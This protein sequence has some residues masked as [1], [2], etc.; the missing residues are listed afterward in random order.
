M[1]NK[2][3]RKVQVIENDYNPNNYNPFLEKDND[4]IISPFIGFKTV[5]ELM[6][7]STLLKDMIHALVD[8]IFWD[9]NSNNEDIL[10]GKSKNELITIIREWLKFGAGCFIL[11]ST[12]FEH[13]PISRCEIIKQNHD[14]FMRYD[15]GNSKVVFNIL[16]RTHNPV[17]SYESVYWIGGDSD[18]LFYTEQEW[19]NKYFTLF[20]EIGVNKYFQGV[21]EG[22]SLIDSILTVSGDLQDTYDEELREYIGSVGDGLAILTFKPNESSDIETNPDVNLFNLSRQSDELYNNIL[23]KSVHFLLSSYQMP[24]V[25]LGIDIGTESMNSHKNKLLYDI[26]IRTVNN[27]QSRVQELLHEILPE[28]KFEFNSLT[29]FEDEI[30]SKENAREDTSVMT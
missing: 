14:F 6:L 7:R 13:V 20:K 12:G 24:A 17:A 9:V 26:Y 1:I 19:I 11:T 5:K 2:L 3:T 25:R 8:D 16:N 15:K 18:N 29:M 23:E 27:Y 10:S 21:M 4:L 30:T 22:G 28:L